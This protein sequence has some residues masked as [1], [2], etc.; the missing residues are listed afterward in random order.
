MWTIGEAVVE[1][2]AVQ[3]LAERA[4]YLASMFGSTATKGT[5]Q[6]LDVLMTPFSE[7]GQDRALFASEFGGQL[8]RRRV[9]EA[10]GVCSYEVL[11]GGRVFHFVFGVVTKG[12]G[13][14]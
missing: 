8:L 14:R 10:R 13:A 1:F 5:G 6:D 11:K 9:N 3:D 12:K 4:G 2:A 7:V